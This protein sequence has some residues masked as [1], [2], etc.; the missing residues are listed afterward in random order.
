MYDVC[1]VGVGVAVFCAPV[2]L[3]ANKSNNA[4]K[5]ANATTIKTL[6]ILTS[7]LPGE[8]YDTATVVS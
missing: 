1:G 5:K 2:G 8:C 6:F 4:A 7:S 3:C